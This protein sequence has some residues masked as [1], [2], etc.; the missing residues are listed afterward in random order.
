MELSA[1]RRRLYTRCVERVS[2]VFTTASSSN[3][4][5][6]LRDPL[7]AAGA[8]ALSQ[9]SRTALPIPVRYTAI[10]AAAPTAHSNEDMGP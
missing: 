10:E 5:A 8:G 7:A 4:A 2:V 9:M 1:V 6:G 3:S